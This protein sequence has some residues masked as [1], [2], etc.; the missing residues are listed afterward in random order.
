MSKIYFVSMFYSAAIIKDKRKK[1]WQYYLEN[2]L[3]EVI[4][5]YVEIYNLL[6]DSI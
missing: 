6:T 3:L 4:F 5:Y 2:K 1:S